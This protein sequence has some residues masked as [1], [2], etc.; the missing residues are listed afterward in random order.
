MR[1]TFGA[2]VACSLLA[3]VPTVPPADPAEQ[4]PSDQTIFE[5]RMKAADQAHCAR[6]AELL[7]EPDDI[8]S[9]VPQTLHSAQRFLTRVVAR[10]GVTIDAETDG[11]WNVGRGLDFTAG[12]DVYKKFPPS[13]VLGS[14]DSG[15]CWTNLRTEDP[16]HIVRGEPG[17]RVEIVP[18]IQGPLSLAW[19]AITAVEQD[20]EAV[21]LSGVS[22]MYF[23]GRLRLHFGSDDMAT[24]VAYVFEFLRVYCKEEL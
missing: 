6:E 11:R 9:D 5:M 15:E 21:M 18:P 24:R 1:A 2:L 12:R 14:S 7:K 10:G 23:D 3:C 8:D 4:G 20:G 13:T 19:R 16:P 17:A 22:N